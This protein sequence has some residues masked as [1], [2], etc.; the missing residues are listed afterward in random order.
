MIRE[1][2]G[3]YRCVL[4]LPVSCPY[5]M[6]NWFCVCFVSSSAFYFVRFFCVTKSRYATFSINSMTTVVSVMLP[7]RLIVF[8]FKRIARTSVA[9][10]GIREEFEASTAPWKAIFDSVTPHSETLPG[11]WNKLITLERM[12]ILRCLRPD[13]MV[14]A[15]QGFVSGR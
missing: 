15:V 6:S 1:K 12:C 11:R 2:S 10:Q 5:L 4:L 14:P 9:T 13:K 8:S 3:R 7:S